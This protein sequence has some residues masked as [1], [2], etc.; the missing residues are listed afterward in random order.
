M[1]Q[2]LIDSVLWDKRYIK[3][4][5]DIE[6]DERILVLKYPSLEDKNYCNWLRNFHTNEAILNGVPTEKEILNQAREVGLWSD[7]DD[8]I[9]TEIN[10]HIKFLEGEIKNQ[11]FLARKK[12]LEKQLKQ[13]VQNRDEVF[14]KK[15][16]LMINTAEYHGNK[17]A[18]H[19]MV[20]RL[21]FRENGELFWRTDEDF[22]SA[23]ESLI[24]FIG[25]EIINCG[26]LSIPKIREIARSFQWRL[27][28]NFQ[29]EN[30]SGLFS[31][32]IGDLNINQL[33]LIYWSRVYDIVYEDTD[34]PTQDIIDDDDKLD[35]W[36]ANKDL[37]SKDIKKSDSNKKNSVEDHHEKIQVL[38]GFYCEECTCGAIN[39]RGKGIGESTR[40][41]DKCRWGVWIP[42]S[43]EEKAAIADQVYSK[44]NTKVRTFINSEMEKVADRGLTE[45]HKLRDRKARMILGAETKTTKIFK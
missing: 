21:T 12:S 39:R 38:D 44:N 8:K 7:I 23:P 36:L 28:W 6:S 3:L 14:N 18:H 24:Y 20:R 9:F 13:A 17:I 25:N 37:K 32:K 5:D 22:L 2:E 4:P 40:H 34:R 45:E 11:K 33:M 31:C 42:Y 27:I 16:G 43:E 10:D 30:L 15:N 35:I 29:K 19:E 26:I 1:V 41:T